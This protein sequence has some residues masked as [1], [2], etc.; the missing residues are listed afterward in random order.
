MAPLSVS[1]RGIIAE[2]CA[3]PDELAFS[4][5]SASLLANKKIF[6]PMEF[7]QYGY[8]G[9]YLREHEAEA[10]F[11]DATVDRL[12]AF[13]TAVENG[14]GLQAQMIEFVQWKAE[15]KMEKSGRVV[16]TRKL[17]M[18]KRGEEGTG[19]LIMVLDPSMGGL[20]V[21][22]DYDY[23]AGQPR[24][25]QDKGEYLEC[26]EEGEMDAESFGSFVDTWL[27]KGV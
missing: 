16:V 12:S 22:Y 21:D 18:K 11:K 26:V 8:H 7:D 14:E 27:E 20:V 1:M 10:L 5:L 2:L 6:V 17:R 25:F 15:M 13:R 23:F 3:P 4:V 24:K 9:A 19:T